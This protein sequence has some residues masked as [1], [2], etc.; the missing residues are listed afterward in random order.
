[1]GDGRIVN[2][3]ATPAVPLPANRS[4]GKFRPARMPCQI[5]G[6]AGPG[7]QM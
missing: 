2:T 6:K 3:P 1:L 4:P 7:I 5:S